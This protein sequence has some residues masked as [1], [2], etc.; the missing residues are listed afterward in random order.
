MAADTIFPEKRVRNWL[1]ARF[2]PQKYHQ[3]LLD[4]AVRLTGAGKPVDLLP[5]DFVA[6]LVRPVPGAAPSLQA[7]G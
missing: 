7:T 4:E 2:I 1:A 6:H 3:E 5:Y